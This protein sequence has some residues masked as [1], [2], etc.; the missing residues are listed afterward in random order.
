[1]KN[2]AGNNVIGLAYAGGNFIESI[3]GTTCSFKQID[4]ST[5]LGA[6]NVQPVTL[7]SGS[8]IAY[9]MATMV[10]GIGTAKKV[11][12]LQ[13]TGINTYRVAYDIKVRNYGNV[14]LNS[15]QVFDSVKTAFGASFLTASIA[16]VGTLPSGLTL[17]PLFN[18]NNI[19]GIFAA[20]GTM[21]ASPSDSATVRVTVDLL[22][23][24]IA[25][26]YFNSAIGTATGAIFSNIVRDSSDNQATLNADVSGTSVPDL[27]GQGVPTPIT[28]LMWL[29]PGNK[30]KNFNA[31]AN[32]KVNNLYWT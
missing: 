10:T 22:N 12:S 6:T 31:K 20:G 15:V 29:L 32:G 1:M 24:N 2:G 8:F 3:Q 13:K 21:K 26:T 25:S 14:N 9:D 30:I 16:S 23:P 7:A 5:T 28:P 19:A 27:K 17:N 11:Y 4:I 18:G